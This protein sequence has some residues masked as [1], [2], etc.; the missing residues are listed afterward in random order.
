[1]ARP[2][3]LNKVISCLMAQHTHITFNSFNFGPPHLA[4][5][6]S[7]RTSTSICCDFMKEGTSGMAN[8][9]YLATRSIF[10]LWSITTPIWQG[11]K[12]L[13]DHHLR[14]RMIPFAYHLKQF[15]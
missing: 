9:K 10:D 11:I 7:F 1:M 4:S 6:L 2:L 3:I 14:E 15:Y 12:W 5:F 13:E 8:P